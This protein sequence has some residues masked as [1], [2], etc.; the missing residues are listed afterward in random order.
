MSTTKEKVPESVLRC[1]AALK[2]AKSDNDRFASLFVVTKL[3]KADECDKHSLKLLYEAIGFDF[4]NRLLRSTEVPQDCPPFIYKSIALSIVSCFCS[5]TEIVESRAILSI[6]PVLLDI[7]TTSD[8]DDMEDNLMLISD[9]YTCLMAI[10]ASETGKKALMEKDSLLRLTDVYVE[11]MFRHDEALKLLVYLATSQ[12]K[13]LWEGKEEA[14]KQL[15]VRLSSEFN[16]ENTERKFELCKMLAVLITNSPRLPAAELE[17]EEWPRKTLLTLES[18]LCSRIGTSHRDIALQLVAGLLELMGIGWGLKHGPNPRQ[19]LL[20][21]VNLACVEV[22]MKLEDKTLEQ[23]IESADVLVS[24]YSVVEQFITFMTS[25]G[26]LD[27]D[28]K[29][30][31]QAYC[32][33][34][35]AVG[36][37]LALLIQ[38]DEE[39]S[40]E[41]NLPAADRRA[42]FICA[43]IRILGSWLAEE[44][45]SMKEEVCAVL[46]FVITVCGKMYE[47]QKLGAS[48]MPDS[49]RFMLPAFCHL[50]AE[51]APRKI[52]LSQKLPQLLYDYLL[53]QWGIFSKWLAQ[54]PTLAADW[55]HAETTPEEDEKAEANRPESESAIIL[56]C[57]VFMNLAVLEPDL[58]ITDPIFAQLLKFCITNLPPLVHRQDFVVLL[59]NVAVLG[60]LLLRHHT[61]KYS[62]GD[63][64]VFRF[65]QGTVSFLWDAHNSEESCDSLSLVISLRYKKD[66]PDLA[67]LWFLGMQGLSNVMSK[68]EWIVEFIIDSNW[69]Q[70][71]MKTLSRIVAGAIDANTRTAYEDFLCCLVR[72][73]PAKVKAIILDNRGRHTCRTH[74]MKQL[75]ALLDGNTVG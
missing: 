34:K 54:Q 25:Q 40:H 37:I 53:Y 7:V 3:I 15:M 42:Q 44:T 45:T 69:P 49:L 32:A 71:M 9:C 2:G 58:I 22:R 11:E 74:S 18:L 6:I 29:Q 30:R 43:S 39:F 65:I 61:W 51:D 56:V 4:L 47:E 35:G 48:E 14:F 24:C 46:P 10:A 52:M 17:Q 75:L 55:L 66:W 23:A 13:R 72:A 31:E 33:L 57:G 63:S 16:S 62:K 59:G 5:V 27:F 64:A 60:L 68:L 36:A 20:L 8:T 73:E 70:E 12:N 38:T 1:V 21:L 19:F 28:S 67:E 26:F 50:A 41:W